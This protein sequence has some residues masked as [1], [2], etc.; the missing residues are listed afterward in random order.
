MH[1]KQWG[2]EYRTTSVCIDSYE[3]QVLAGRF[4]N[5]YYPEGVQFHSVMD[6]LL[7]MEEMLNQM[8][9]PQAFSGV[10]T[11][12]K[13]ADV[14]IKESHEGKAPAGELATFALKVLFRQ[15]T[16]WQGSVSW[17]EGGREESFRSVLELLFLLDSAVT[18]GQMS[19]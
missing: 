11:F 7:K 16:S 8:N 14:V 3:N 2:N 5:R 9:F 13:V 1:A 18:A 10:R 19:R 6:F 15:N 17:L 12:S 4:Y